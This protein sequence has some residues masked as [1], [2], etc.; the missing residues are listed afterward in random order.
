MIKVDNKFPISCPYKNIHLLGDKITIILED[1]E[2]SQNLGYFLLGAG[3]GELNN[4]RF[5]MLNYQYSK[6]NGGEIILRECLDIFS[7]KIEAQGENFIIDEHLLSQGTYILVSQ[8]GK[9]KERMEIN[10]D[11]DNKV[12]AYYDFQKMDYYSNLVSVNKAVDPKTKK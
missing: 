12:G 6:Q 2:M 1:N 4:R 9:I 7:K 11:N 8:E 10:K 3:L 5:G